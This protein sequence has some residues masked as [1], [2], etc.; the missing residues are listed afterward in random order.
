MDTFDSNLL[1][2]S[3]M[4]MIYKQTLHA[5]AEQLV[6]DM[7]KSQAAARNISLYWLPYVPGCA[8]ACKT[9]PV[10]EKLSPFIFSSGG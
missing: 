4:G 8:D 5:I 9:M 7:A 10:R 3:S 1:S 2:G 6:D